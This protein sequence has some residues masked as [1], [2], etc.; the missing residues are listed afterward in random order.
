VAAQYRPVDWN[1][2]LIAGFVFN[3]PDVETMKFDQRESRLV[4]ALGFSYRYIFKNS[5]SLN[6]SIAAGIFNLEILYRFKKLSGAKM[7]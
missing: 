4:Q 6:T 5:I 7:W 1:P 2:Y 3:N